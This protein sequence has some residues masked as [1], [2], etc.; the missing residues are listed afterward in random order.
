MT[1]GEILRLAQMAGLRVEAA[2]IGPGIMITA[3]PPTALESF[4]R[5][6]ETAERGEACKSIEVVLDEKTCALY[7]ANAKLKDELRNAVARAVL[8]EREACAQICISLAQNEL[9]NIGGQ[10]YDCADAIRARS[11]E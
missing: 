5:L 4:V 6:I 8:E 1:R 7:V 10:C 11:D 3:S 9:G 2:N